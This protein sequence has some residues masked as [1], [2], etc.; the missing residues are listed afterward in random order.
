MDMGCTWK[1]LYLQFKHD[2]LWSLCP[3]RDLLS[4]ATEAKSYLL[5]V[6]TCWRGTNS[7]PSGRGAI[8]LVPVVSSVRSS[9][10][11]ELGC[12]QKAH[13]SCQCCLLPNLVPLVF[14]NCI[15]ASYPWLQ[16]KDELNGH[17]EKLTQLALP[18]IA[19]LWMALLPLVKEWQR[20]METPATS[21]SSFPFF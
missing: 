1:L 17:S 18:A 21:W 9:T 3:L 8:S 7:V 10:S 5:K 20:N 13:Y 14:S 19:L 15:Q 11:A 12:T 2:C 4:Q 6:P 16:G